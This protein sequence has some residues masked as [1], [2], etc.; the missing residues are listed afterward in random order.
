MSLNK[1]EH[2]KTWLPNSMEQSP[3]E[4]NIHSASQEISSR[5]FITVFTRARHWSLFRA[6]CIQ[7]HAFPPW[8]SKANVKLS[9]YLTMHHPM[10]TYW[11][12]EVIVPRILDLCTRWRWVVNFTPL[13][14]Y[15]QGKNPWYPLERIHSNII[16]PSM[17]RSSKWSLPFRFCNLNIACISHLSHACYMPRSSHPPW[18]EHPNIWW[19]VQVMKLPTMQSSSASRYFIPL[20]YKYHSQHPVL[21]HNPC[22]SL[23]VRNQISHP[24]KQH[25]PIWSE[26]GGP[27][28]VWTRWRREKNL[29]HM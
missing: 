28:P 25:V 4:A 3:W 23:D 24:Y 10:K 27:K 19:S 29:C 22:S 9:L 1:P 5:R 26:A 11:R 8:F 21:K 16:F 12:S 2:S 6:R 18:L 17:S 14:L 7:V 20:R 15:L 13:P